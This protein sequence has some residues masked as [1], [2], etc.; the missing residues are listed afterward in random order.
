MPCG[1]EGVK[2]SRLLFVDDALIFYE[3]SQDHLTFLCWLLMWLEVLS[4]LKIVE[5]KKEELEERIP[6]IF[7]IDLNMYKYKS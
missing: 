2:V 7:S 1:Q 6:S 3:A 5:N 4:E